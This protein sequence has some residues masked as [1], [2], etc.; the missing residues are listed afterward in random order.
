MGLNIP[1]S[2]TDIASVAKMLF[3]GTITGFL[4]SVWTQ[5]IT[6]SLVGALSGR[7]YAV[8]RCLSDGSSE[9]DFPDVC[10]SEIPGTMIIVHAEFPLTA[11]R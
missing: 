4:S 8:Y 10:G 11:R 2:W 3:R 5:S 7:L 1:Q 9:Q 6:G